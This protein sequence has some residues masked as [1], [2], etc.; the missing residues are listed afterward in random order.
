M[1]WIFD[2]SSSHAAMA[3]DSLHVNLMN[4]RPGGKQRIMSGMECFME[5][6]KKKRHQMEFQGLRMVLEERGV[7]T[8]GMTAIKMRE[9]F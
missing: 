3:N 8:A 9:V 2:H 7:N 6:F 4:V 5:K 1:V